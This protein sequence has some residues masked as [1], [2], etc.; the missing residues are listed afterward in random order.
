M[1]TGRTLGQMCG[2]K[3]LWV[4]GP[5]STIAAAAQVMRD[6][7]VGAVLVSEDGRLNGILSE[8]DVTYRAVAAGLDPNITAVSEVMTRKVIT[9]GPETRAVNGLQQMAEN[10]IRH[11]PVTDG[12]TVIG[13]VS[14][15]DFLTEELA[16]VQ[17]E[18]SFEG[19]VAEELW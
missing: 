1:T 19:A 10:Q 7:R 5:N 17:D 13:I 8:R 11:L 18:I 3:D 14:L 4:V 2:K 15:R 16:Q 9:A 6:N 12:G